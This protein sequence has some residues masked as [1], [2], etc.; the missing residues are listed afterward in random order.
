M[1]RRPSQPGYPGSRRRPGSIG[2]PLRSRGRTRRRRVPG[3]E[4]RTDRGQRVE[5]VS[6][7]RRNR[8]SRIRMAV[9]DLVPFPAATPV[10]HRRRSSWP[11]STASASRSTGAGSRL[12]PALGGSG[13]ACRGEAV[14]EHEERRR[15]VLRSGSAAIQLDQRLCRV[16]VN[17]G[18]RL[19]TQLLHPDVV[20]IPLQTR[21]H[22]KK[23]TGVQCLRRPLPLVVEVWSP[24]G[25]TTLRRSCRAIGSVGDA[26]IWFIHSLRDIDRLAETADGSYAEETLGGAELSRSLLRHRL[27]R[28]AGRVVSGHS[29]IVHPVPAR[30]RAVHA[31]CRSCR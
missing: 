1:S 8:K 18:A 31:R 14:D 3:A 4:R 12:G 27:R 30:F 7:G 24:T 26:E 17:G 19:S 5:V 23:S 16:N 25:R 15:G 28:P 20:V 29:S 2:T 22:S 9:T 21:R 6:R 10:P 11:S 13:M